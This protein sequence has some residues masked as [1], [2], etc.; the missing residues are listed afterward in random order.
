VNAVTVESEGYL[1]QR[2]TAGNHTITADEL[3]SA[4]GQDSGPDP[5]SLLLGSL[6]A[7][8]SM[9]IQMYAR[10]KGF[11]LEKVSVRLT[12]ERIYANDCDECESKDG[13]VGRI[14]RHIN[15]SGPLSVEQRARLL[16]IAGK[17]PVAKTLKSE[18]LIKDFL[19]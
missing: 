17:C 8:T 12:H 9:T 4:G 18:L 15:L 19:D 5:Y 6:G 11:P 2:I 16:E 7:C 10:H 14:E 3:V 13:M 1:K